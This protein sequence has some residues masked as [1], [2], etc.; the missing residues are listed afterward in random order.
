[1][2]TRLLLLN[3]LQI[4]AATE[5]VDTSSHRF[6]LF[7]AR[8]RVNRSSPNCAKSHV[9]SRLGAARLPLLLQS[10][11]RKAPPKLAC[12][13]PTS[14][15][16]EKVKRLAMTRAGPRLA[17]PRPARLS[18]AAGSDRT[19]Y[20]IPAATLCVRLSVRTDIPQF[21][22]PSTTMRRRGVTPPIKIYTWIPLLL[23]TQCVLGSEITSSPRLLE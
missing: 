7:R 9:P 6:S 15:R 22:S 19:G 1:V 5:T 4:S 14:G 13:T 2:I 23:A 8:H 11:L 10:C 20:S 21:V 12:N 18:L 3:A 17:K 16:A